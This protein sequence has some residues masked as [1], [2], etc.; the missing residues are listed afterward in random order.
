MVRLPPE[1]TPLVGR[2]ADIERVVHLFEGEGARL[3]S[4]LGPA[5]I[6]KTRL[7]LACARA[8]SD[9]ETRFV[10]L[11]AAHGDEDVCTEVAAVLGVDLSAVA[12]ALAALGPTLLVC[13]NFEQALVAAPRLVSWLDRAP[14]LRLLVTSRA[15]LQV[16]AEV[17]HRVGPLP[18]AEELFVRRARSVRP[19]FVA[20]AALADL[21]ARLDGMPLA[22]ELSAARMAVMSPAQLLARLDRDVLVG[23]RTLRGALDSS[24]Q[25]MSGPAR[26]ALARCGVF[27]GGFDLDAAEAVL[28]EGAIDRVQ[29]LVDQSLVRVVETPLGPRFAMYEAIRAYAVERLEAKGPAQSA[30]ATWFLAAAEARRLA[31]DGPDGRTAR[32]WL[33]TERENL[34]AIREARPD[35]AEQVLWLLDP[36]LAARGPFGL[37][38]RWLDDALAARPSARGHLLR[39]ALRRRRGRLDAAVA[40]LERAVD[41]ADGAVAAQARLELGIAVFEQGDHARAQNLHTEALERFRGLGDVRGEGCALGGMAIIDHE[42]GRVDDA[43][44]R[45]ERALR[46]LREAGDERSV[47]VFLSNLGD[48]HLEHAQPGEA[49]A[50]YRRAKEIADGLGDARLAG[51]VLGNLGAVALDEGRHDD[52][53]RLRDEAV[54]CLRR[55]G[56]RRMEAVFTGYL[57]A[58][59]HARAEAR[60]DADERTSARARYDAAIAHL[61]GRYA[62]LF[63]AY[64]AAL[65]TPEV[66]RAALDA[67][68]GEADPVVTAVVALQ[69][70]RLDLASGAVDAARARL[71][72]AVVA[73][74][75]VR[76][77]RRLLSA[78]LPDAPSRAGTAALVVEGALIAPPDGAAFDLARRPTL[79]R[80]FEGLLAQRLEAPGEPLDLDALL[81]AGWPGEKVLP[82]AAANRVY[83]A[84]ATLRKLG[85]RSVLLSREL[86]YLLDP[87]VD[88]RVKGGRS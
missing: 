72:G 82:D 73:S 65:Q 36:V 50:N 75:D 79:G 21:L 61:E 56:D 17:V 16:S 38:E 8:T 87:D 40:D 63:R 53:V 28:G 24:W 68:A 25:L 70:G 5:G 67:L 46:L 2:V 12:D 57:G 55:V 15:R 4:L 9:V 81:A 83:V 1:P 33:A 74:D 77:A 20:D 30:H 54:E 32:S 88:L 13:D 84:I 62:A 43:Q 51:V 18:E 76:F 26:E 39:G 60:D 59:L 86:G 45:Y 11:T 71:S 19:S 3:V 78:A 10:D 6:G 52:A 64:R 80:V 35:L 31:I 7:A 41:L 14:A 66:A 42:R 48:L 22:I 44:T 37:H 27:R 23:E 85:L 29:A 47:A 49:R 58:A 69:R 34:L